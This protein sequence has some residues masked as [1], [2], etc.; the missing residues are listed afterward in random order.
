MFCNRHQN[1]KK[2]YLETKTKP[3]SGHWY[4]DLKMSE[5]LFNPDKAGKAPFLG[6]KV[7]ASCLLHMPTGGATVNLIFLKQK[8]FQTCVFLDSC[9]VAVIHNKGV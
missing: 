7:E 4:Q 8:H 1:K 6:K 9:L 3:A 5:W 2:N